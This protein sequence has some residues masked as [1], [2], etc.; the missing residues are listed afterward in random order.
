MKPA[1]EDIKRTENDLHFAVPKVL[2]SAC[3]QI[4]KTLDT[5]VQNGTLSNSSQIKEKSNCVRKSRKRLVVMDEFSREARNET[6]KSN[7]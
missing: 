2:Q 5:N 4:S 3:V 6:F 1:D 7:D